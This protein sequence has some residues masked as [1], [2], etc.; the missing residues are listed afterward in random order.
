MRDRYLYVRVLEACNA[1][2]FMCSFA[3]STNSYRLG[4]DE[5]AENLPLAKAVGITYIR[6]TGGEPLMHHG[7]IDIVRLGAEAGFRMAMITNGHLLPRRAAELAEAGLA[8]IIVS[9]DGATAEVHDRIRNFDGLFGRACEGV[10]A[11]GDLGVRLR[12]NTVVGP[13]N[14]Q[15]MPALQRLLVE[16]G[17]VQ[18][19][20]SAVKLDQPITYPDPADVVRVGEEVFAGP[21]RPMGKRWYGETP[22]EQA[23]Y[24]GFGLPPRASEPRCHVTDDVL[25]LDPRT[26]RLAPCSLLPHRTV[27]DQ[28]AVTIGRRTGWDLDG[29]EIREAKAYFSVHGP[30]VC[31]GCSSSASGY[32]DAIGRDGKALDWAY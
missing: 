19:E 13:H 5:F 25:Y 4:V 22:D 3:L 21:L 14:Y 15:Q 24:F 16:M 11:M 9:I 30:S 18:W 23:A 31:T 28:V 8:Q 10:R 29:E 27:A 32:S 26:S 2:C 17:V 6:L 7:I 12:V 1:D 20:L